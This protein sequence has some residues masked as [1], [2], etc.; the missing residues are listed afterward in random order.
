MGYREDRGTLRRL[1]ARLS[2]RG[3]PEPD[4]GLVQPWERVVMFAE[5]LGVEH[6]YML[7]LY[8][9]QFSK[10]VKGDY[11]QWDEIADIEI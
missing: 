1:K 2:A 8:P 3:I 6:P 4:T 7:V 10:I 11:S 9:D 5:A